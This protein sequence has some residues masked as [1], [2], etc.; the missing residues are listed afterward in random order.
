VEAKLTALDHKI[1]R[2][3]AQIIGLLSRLV[4]EDPDAV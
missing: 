4:G 3:Q 1:D 2:N